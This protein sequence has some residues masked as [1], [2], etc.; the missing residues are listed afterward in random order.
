MI[1]QPKRK[2][3]GDAHLA[4]VMR[5]L[6]IKAPT[7]RVVRADWLA[8]ALNTDKIGIMKKVV[9]LECGHRAIVRLAATTAKCHE[10]H[11]MI[12]N[13]EDYEAFRNDR[14]TTPSTKQKG[15]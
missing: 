3:E 5:K 10:C 9:E 1:W 6:K 15:T 14:P 12:L 13:G 11:K 4:A 8:T 7:E 2:P